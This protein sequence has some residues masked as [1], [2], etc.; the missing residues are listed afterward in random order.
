M[1]CWQRLVT[2]PGQVQIPGHGLHI[3]I[4]FGGSGE[5]EEVE[6]E[7]EKEVKELKKKREELSNRWK[8]SS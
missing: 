1:A 4:L 5:G 6:K 7:E 8:R 3:C 2:A